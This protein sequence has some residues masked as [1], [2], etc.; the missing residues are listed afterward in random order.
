MV[1]YKFNPYREDDFND[2]NFYPLNTEKFLDEYDDSQNID[3]IDLSDFNSVSD[4][5]DFQSSPVDS[6]IDNDFIPFSNVFD[7]SIIPFRGETTYENKVL[8]NIQTIPQDLTLLK[9]IENNVLF[10]PEEDMMEEIEPL[11]PDIY[12][13]QSSTDE[14]LNGETEIVDIY[15]IERILN[16]IEEN[17]PLLIKALLTPNNS[18]PSARITLRKIIKLT[19]KYHYEK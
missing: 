5:S 4:N 11:F 19:L 3:T 2:F 10:Q 1:P 16:N 6:I 18:Y 9:D 15:E 13:S 7:S 17:D 12:Q 14:E 8:P